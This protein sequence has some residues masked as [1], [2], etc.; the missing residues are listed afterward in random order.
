MPNMS[1]ANRHPFLMLYVLFNELVIPELKMEQYE[2]VQRHYKSEIER[3]SVEA[4]VSR[5]LMGNIPAW[6]LEEH[7]TIHDAYLQDQGRRDCLK[8]PLILRASISLALAER[9]RVLGKKEEAQTLIATAV[10]NYPGYSPFSQIEQSLN[11]NQEIPWEVRVHSTQQ[12][13]KSVA[14]RLSPGGTV[15]TSDVSD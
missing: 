5:L 15:A 6:P 4:M 13:H 2:N 12:L 10:D 11:A 1:E 8:L 7:R 9:Y 3:P 14:K